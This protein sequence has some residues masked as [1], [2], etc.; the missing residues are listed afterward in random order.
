MYDLLQFV[1]S[2]YHLEFNPLVSSQLNRAIH[3][4]ADKGRFVLPK[5]KFPLNY[6]GSSYFLRD[7]ISGPSGKVKLAPRKHNEAAK[8]VRH[9]FLL[10]V[11]SS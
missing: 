6:H 5:G 7:S 4:G 10:L 3:Q 2:K 8:E 1:D 11:S 9:A